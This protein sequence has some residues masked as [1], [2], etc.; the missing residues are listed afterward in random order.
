MLY[1]IFETVSFISIKAIFSCIWIRTK[2]FQSTF[3]FIYVGFTVIPE[4]V[5][6]F[7]ED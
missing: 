1:N 7:T 5:L 3:P 2:D 4:E 6:L